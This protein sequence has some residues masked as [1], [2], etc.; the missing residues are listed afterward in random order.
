M[1]GGAQPSAKLCFASIFR[2]GIYVFTVNQTQAKGAA[3][4]MSP[5]RLPLPAQNREA[6]LMLDPEQKA[7]VE[8][9]CGRILVVASAGSGKTRVL[10]ERVRW[11]IE[12]GVAPSLILCV[13][14]TRNA[15]E[16]IKE[17]LCDLPGIKE[18]WIGT[19]HSVCYRILRA[20]ASALRILGYKEKFTVVDEDEA[21]AIVKDVLKEL[22]LEANVK[23]VLSAMSFCRLTLRD[24]ESSCFAYLKEVAALYMERLRMMNLI[25]FDGLLVNVLKLFRANEKVRLKYAKKFSHVLIDEFQDVDPC[26]WEIVKLLTSVH[27]NLFCV[28]DPRQSIYSFRG[29]DV[30]IILQYMRDP[31]TRIY[32]LKRNYRSTANIIAAADSVIRNGM[33][34]VLDP[35]VPVRGQGEP[36]ELYV[37]PNELD[38][39]THVA[40]SIKE[41]IARGVKPE[42]VAVLARTVHQ[43]GLIDIALYRLGVPHEIYGRMSLLE[44]AVVK[45]VMAFLRLAVN[46]SDIPAFRRAAGALNGIG[47]KTIAK[48]ALLAEGKSV[49]EALASGELWLPGPARD[50]LSRLLDLVNA[51]PKMK[52]KEAIEAIWKLEALKKTPE[53]GPIVEEFLRLAKSFQDEN[54]EMSLEEFIGLV[55]PG[56]TS[57]AEEDGEDAVKLMTIHAAKGKEFQYVFLVGLEEGILPHYN[58]MDVEEERRLLYVG[59]TRAMERLYLS[60]AEERG[61]GG[62]IVRREISRFLKQVEPGFLKPVLKEKAQPLAEIG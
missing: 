47:P 16:E 54:P 61:F 48:V 59:I 51:I 7:A 10:T 49:E 22:G 27:G 3:G 21:E 9:P 57:D 33:G 11:L 26:Q 5:L 30:D 35:Q 29:G 2:L 17:R 1:R 62:R 28:G 56:S 44:R 15:A 32:K 13:T 12:R 25:D 38:E 14:F 4:I 53:D 23:E 58:A 60:Y 42:D 36:I 50:S 6:M 39:A 43:L 24:M 18:L 31:E 20:E 34:G 46:N 40:E 8:A 45:T 55:M 37:A 52:P 41:L 19:F